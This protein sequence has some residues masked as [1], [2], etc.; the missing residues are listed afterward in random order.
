MGSGL[1]KAVKEAFQKAARS[2]G[3]RRKETV[4]RVSERT[5]RVGGRFYTPTAKGRLREVTGKELSRRRKIAETVKKQ[6][7]RGDRAKRS[8]VGVLLTQP[9]AHIRAARRARGEAD[10]PETVVVDLGIVT[11]LQGQ[12]VLNEAI[13][14]RL[15][16]GEYVTDRGVWFP[17][18]IDKVD[19]TW[20]AWLSDSP[21]DLEDELPEREDE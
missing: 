14:A 19:L 1:R 4:Q 2:L 16:A 3:L 20:S 11:R 15:D 7:A 21:E 8:R 10:Y 9:P 12:R 18:N 5:V 6:Y 13:K 17:E